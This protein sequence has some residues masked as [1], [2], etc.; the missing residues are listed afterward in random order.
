MSQMFIDAEKYLSYPS[1]CT[2][3]GTKFKD[4]HPIMYCGYP[5]KDNDECTYEKEG[6]CPYKM[7]GRELFEDWTRLKFLTEPMLYKGEK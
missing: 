3:Y 4:C 6:D 2:F 7:T 5:F 1:L